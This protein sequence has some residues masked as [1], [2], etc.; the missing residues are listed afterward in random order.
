MRA[1]TN[2]MVFVVRY[3][4]LEGGMASFALK[5]HWVR[6]ALS[7]VRRTSPWWPIRGMPLR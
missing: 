5:W 4:V 7:R 1:R 6:T 3:V 2:C